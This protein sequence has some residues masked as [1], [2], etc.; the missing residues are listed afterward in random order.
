MED[1][2]Q[3][4]RKTF[5][6]KINAIY[7]FRRPVKL[8]VESPLEHDFI[9]RKDYQTPIKEILLSTSLQFM[10]SPIRTTRSLIKLI[11]ICFLITSLCLS[12]YFVTTNIIEYLN[13]DTTTSIE[14]IY[15]NEANLPAISFCSFKE[16]FINIK[17]L[18]LNNQIIKEWE[19]YFE[20]IPD[21]S[22]GM[23]YRLN[24]GFNFSNQITSIRKQKHSGF[25][26]GFSI[27]FYS[28]SE[29][30]L[31]SIHNQTTR[32][33][34]I[35]KNFYIVANFHNY[36]LLKRTY[37]QKLE[38]PY[39]DCFKN[40]A[41]F[42]QNKTIINFFQNKSSLYS[43]KECKRMYQVLRFKEKSDCNCTVDSLDE[44]LYQKCYYEK[45]T[46]TQ[47]CYIKFMDTFSSDHFG[48]FIDYCP[49]ECDSF[50]YDITPYIM[51]NNQNITYLNGVYQN[52]TYNI[53]VY[54][55]D[56]RYTY[57]SQKVKIEFVGLISNI[58]GSMGL[59]VGISF[60]S[61][62]EMFEILAEVA[63]IY[64]E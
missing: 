2:N 14:T 47:N 56:L 51:F 38:S 29:Q 32:P 50:S 30:I 27:E 37:D 11:N 63:Y 26:Y 18:M 52:S 57:I 20:K 25:D 41:D 21:Y 59:F 45:D 62:I 17:V 39:N 40:V 12:V 49:M 16:K 48:Q 64:F 35:Q 8:S 33:L 19:N 13:Y 4:R 34:S 24:S 42:E 10:L 28:N 9:Q 23:C 54:Y 43:Q 53:R 7:L 60:L 55:E 1:L 36:F 61:F 58:G 22:Y 31:L 6:E 44:E 15:E 3:T 5:L 46:K